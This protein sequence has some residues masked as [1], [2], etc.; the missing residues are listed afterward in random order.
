MPVGQHTVGGME[1]LVNG[2]NSDHLDSQ[3]FSSRDVQTAEKDK[4]ESSRVRVRGVQAQRLHRQPHFRGGT[5]GLWPVC[6]CPGMHIMCVRTV[7][8]G[9][10]GTFLLLKVFPSL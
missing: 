5:G 1:G 2:P 6:G 3:I 9:T 7:L 10:Q 4:W 8:A